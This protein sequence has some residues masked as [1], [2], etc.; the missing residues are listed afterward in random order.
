MEAA[1]GS[2]TAAATTLSLGLDWAKA[3]LS[4][5]KGKMLT[6]FTSRVL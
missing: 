5:K 2:Y 1:N 3:S 4:H 6:T